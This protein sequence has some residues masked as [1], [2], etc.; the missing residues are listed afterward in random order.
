MICALYGTYLA[1]TA[2]PQF[3]FALAVMRAQSWYL[4]AAGLLVI[5]GTY[6]VY[7]YHPPNWNGIPCFREED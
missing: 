5:I 4:L 2:Y 1:L 6:F 3:G 7:P